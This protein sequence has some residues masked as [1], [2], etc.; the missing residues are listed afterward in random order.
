MIPTGQFPHP[1]SG[2]V[3]FPEPG[4]AGGAAGGVPKARLV[5]LDPAQL[6]DPSKGLQVELVDGEVTLGRSDENSVPLKCSGI[7]RHHA[8]VFPSGDGWMVQDLD[9]TNGIKV[10]D[11]KVKEAKLSAGDT[12]VIGKVPFQF[13][14]VRPDIKGMVMKDGTAVEQ[15]ENWNEMTISDRTMFVSSDLQAAAVLL[16]AKAKEDAARAEDSTDRQ[17]TGRVSSHG[18]AA[19]VKPQGKLVKRLVLIFLVLGVIGGGWYGYQ[20]FFGSGQEEALVKAYRKDIRGFL[21]DYEG[22]GSRYSRAAYD[23]ALTVLANISANIDDGARQYPDSLAIKALQA[24]AL[25]L[26]FERQLQQMLAESQFDEARALHEQA[27]ERFQILR[28]ALSRAR[29]PELRSRAGQIAGLLELAGPVIAIRAFV[30]QYPQPLG[31]AVEKPSQSTLDELM[32]TRRRFAQLRRDNNLA[33]SV[34]FPFFNGIV[35]DVDQNDIII[36]DRWG[37]VLRQEM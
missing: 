18:V 35:G 13:V 19:V 21:Q 7:S 17:G 28:Q 15:A 31:D 2:I 24:D 29:D 4:A 30:H 12:V 9:S 25:F 34:S 11:K 8:R 32:D 20:H 10:N 14:L 36:L 1:G 37:A 23:Q 5:C 27:N 22:L 26:L 33:L 3:Q 16:D 6:P